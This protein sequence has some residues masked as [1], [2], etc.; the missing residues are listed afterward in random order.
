MKSL[1]F[2]D[3][4]IGRAARIPAPPGS[5]PRVRWARAA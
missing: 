3:P 2:V 1:H 4:P 5:T